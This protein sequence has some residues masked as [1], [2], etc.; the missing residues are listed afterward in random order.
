MCLHVIP[1]CKLTKVLAL[2]NR[3]G[4]RKVTSH[5]CTVDFVSATSVLFCGL[6][7]GP[8]DTTRPGCPCPAPPP[9]GFPHPDCSPGFHFSPR[10]HQSLPQQC[11]SREGLQLHT[12]LPCLDKSH[13]RAQVPG[14]P[15]PVSK[16]REVPDALGWGCPGTPQLPCS[17][18]RWCDKPW[19]PGPALVEP[20]GHPD[21]PSATAPGSC[22]PCCA[23]TLT[24]DLLK[25]KLKFLHS[26]FSFAM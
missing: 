7:Q 13:P 26:Y 3:S 23:L 21:T 24:L 19:P 8:E 1:L 6:R 16:P 5:F 2:C 14:W 17:C 18:L 22:W 12:A 4:R 25:Y 10:G 9:W 20:W 11:C 15:W